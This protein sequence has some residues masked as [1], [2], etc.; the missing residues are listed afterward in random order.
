MKVV[1]DEKA[2]RAKQQMNLPGSYQNNQRAIAK[3]HK[4]NMD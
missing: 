2:V 3:T 4:K 1:V